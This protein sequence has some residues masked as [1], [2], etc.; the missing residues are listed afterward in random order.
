MALTGLHSDG[1]G[2]ACGNGRNAVAEYGIS[3]QK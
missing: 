1:S 2:W 3:V